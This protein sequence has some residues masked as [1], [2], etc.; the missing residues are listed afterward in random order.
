MKVLLYFE[1]ESM[2]S[3]SGIGRALKHQQAALDAVG[4]EWTCD[5]SDD[6][7]ILHINTVGPNSSHMIKQAKE[8]GRKVIYHAHSTEEDFRNSFVFSNTIAPMFKKHLINLYSQADL[9]ITPTPY[10]KRLLEGYELQQPIYAISNGIDLQRFS[11]NE[12]KVK[13]FRKYFSLD[14]KDK[15]VL[16][17]GLFFERKGILD[18]VE[19]A[20]R[21]PEYKFIWFGSINNMMIPSHVRDI[22]QGN[23]PNN[24]I[25]PGYVKGA[26]IEGAFSGSDVFF[27]PSYEETEGIV[28]L[29]ALASHQN[30]IV[31]DIGVYDEWL[32]DQVN[33]YKG[34]NND[35]FVQLIQDVIEKRV[36]SVKEEGY[37]TAQER[38]IDFIGQQLQSVYKQVLENNEKFNS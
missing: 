21:M 14:E 6:Y 24:V 13:A 23:H 34:T 31:R 1:G 7:D 12:E 29:E 2:I 19:V 10:S 15:V 27:F 32:F 38:S 25:F 16:C 3:G 33:C 28:V 22:V 30:V 36:P 4:I 20:K 17:V 37:K 5:P 18:F 8:L 11:Y 26:I 35:V 9:I